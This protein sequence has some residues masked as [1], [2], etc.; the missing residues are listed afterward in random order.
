MDPVVATYVLYL[1]VSVALTFWVARTLFLN[2]RP[3]LLD[4]FRDETLA[5]SV[6]RL[7]VVGFYLVNFGYVALAMRL[8][9]DAVVYGSREVLEVLAGKVGLVL[10]VLGCMHFGNL[11]V[12]H[13]IRRRAT[14]RVPRIG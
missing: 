4:V 2:G 5:D 1:A 3:F 6:N 13:R 10:L 14:V 11:Y 9:P 12:F 8:S 7:L